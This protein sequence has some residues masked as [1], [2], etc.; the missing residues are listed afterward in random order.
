MKFCSKC[1]APLNINSKFCTGCGQSL[2]STINLVKK[3]LK[4]EAPKK[5]VPPTPPKKG[6]PAWVWIIIVVFI[7]GV[8]ASI[9]MIYKTITYPKNEAQVENLI[10]NKYWKE[11][12]FTIEEIYYDGKLVR[13]GSNIVSKIENAVKGMNGEDVYKKMENDLK[14][15]WSYDNFIYYK[16]MSDGSYWQYSQWMDSK[17][18]KDYLFSADNFSFEKKSGHFVLTNQSKTEYSYYVETGTLFDSYEVE[19]DKDEIISLNEKELTVK[20]TIVMGNIK[21]VCSVT[22]KN[23]SE[24]LHDTKQLKSYL[25][26]FELG[27][28]FTEPATEPTEPL[29]SDM[30]NEATVDTAAIEVDTTEAY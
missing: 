2:K 21:I 19:E 28:G 14:A 16:K 18:L 12:N 17:E 23:T 5:I 7:I 4:P 24:Y 29:N 22:Y 1:G 13:K 3:D 11:D 20:H 27:N 10:C 9:R 15:M 26:L 30:M 8:I 25:T 6:M